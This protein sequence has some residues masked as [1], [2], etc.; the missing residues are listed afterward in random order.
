MAQTER[1][2]TA[3]SNPLEPLSAEEISAAVEVLRG[4]QGLTESYRF[5]SVVLHEPPKAQ[6]LNP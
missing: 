2:T 3:A 4:E 6:V 5:V 1:H